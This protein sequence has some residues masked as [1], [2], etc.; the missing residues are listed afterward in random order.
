MFVCDLCC[1][2][3][4]DKE[5]VDIICEEDNGPVPKGEVAVTTCKFC[6]LQHPADCLCPY[7]YPREKE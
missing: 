2:E 6:Q 1:G 7:L 3:Y 5:R 4:D